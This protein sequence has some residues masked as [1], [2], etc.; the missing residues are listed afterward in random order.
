MPVGQPT[1]TTHTYACTVITSDPVSGKIE[2]GIPGNL[3]NVIVVSTPVAFRWPVAGET[4]RVEYVNGQFFLR[5]PYPLLNPGSVAATTTT[6][7]TTIN[8]IEPGDAVL[9]SPTG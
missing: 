1:P 3:E 2:I 7:S 8:T 4:W 5:D 9:N 6:A